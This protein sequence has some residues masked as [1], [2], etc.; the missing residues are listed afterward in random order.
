MP[1]GVRT[2]EHAATPR[3]RELSKALHEFLV[4]FVQAVVD[5]EIKIDV[6]QRS[7]SQETTNLIAAL[8][9]FI[10]TVV[11]TAVRTRAEINLEE[12]HREVTSIE[13]VN[14]AVEKVKYTRSVTLDVSRSPYPQYTVQQT[15]FKALRDHVFNRMPIRLLSFEQRGSS[16][17]ITLLEREEILMRLESKLGGLWNTEH[18]HNGL[19]EI[20]TQNDAKLIMPF[21]RAHAAYA[22]LSHT[23]FR[24][25]P[26]EVTYSDWINRRFNE[27]DPGYQKLVNFCKVA[28]KTHKLS[29][30]WMDT[31]CI[32]KDSSSELDESIRSMYNWYRR[33]AVCVVFLSETYALSNIHQ[34]PWFTRGWTLQELLAP[35]VLK[36]YNKNWWPFVQYTKDD[37]RSSGSEEVRSQIT[38]ATTINEAELCDIITEASLSRRMQLAARRDVTREE[39]MA[40]SLM[41]IFDVSMATAYGEGGRR[42]FSRLLREILSST[43]TGIVDLFNWAGRDASS[44]SNILPASPR[45]FAYRSSSLHLRRDLQFHKPCEPLTLTHAGIRIPILLMPGISVRNEHSAFKPV[46]EFTA[47]ANISATVDD[48]HIPTTYHLLDSRVSMKDGRGKVIVEDGIKVLAHQYTFAV[49]NAEMNVLGRIRIPQV[50]IAVPIACSEKAGSVTDM[51]NFTRIFTQAPV[52]FKLL[53]K[54]LPQALSY[55]E[56]H[57]SGVDLALDALESHGMQLVV[58]HM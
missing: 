42:A 14:R 33:A 48:E 20:A 6:E 1:F 28:W 57:F 53:R 17:E 36:F 30:G 46:G 44:I 55:S 23:W 38:K 22:I 5:P 52:V 18:P 51:G 41:G 31:I 54:R 27:T 39:D 37:K 35:S 26:G 3:E 40:Y 10:S 45:Q 47:T 21:I 19:S 24:A 58:K 15:L 8:K 34:D 29:F 11:G 49:L 7:F 2:T 32:N 9:T 25:G 50:C 56:L 43:S 16:L 13:P 12:A 4:P